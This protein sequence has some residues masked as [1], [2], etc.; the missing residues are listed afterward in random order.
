MCERCLSIIE[1]APRIYRRPLTAI[2]LEWGD[3][4]NVRDA[5][6]S[7]EEAV[8]R[9]G[10]PVIAKIVEQLVSEYE[11]VVKR[12]DIAG[13]SKVK[14]SYTSDLAAAFKVA[15][16]AA[17]RK[18]K[19]QIREFIKSKGVELAVK[20]PHPLKDADKRAAYL[21]ARADAVSEQVQTQISASVQRTVLAA[22]ATGEW[23]ET[24]AETIA[25]TAA[26]SLVASA[27]EIGREAFAAGRLYGYEEIKQEV[28][29]VVYS[30]VLDEKCCD[31]CA[32]M[33]G[34]VFEDPDEG[35]DAAPNAD[36]EGGISRCRCY[37][38]LILDR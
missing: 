7:A 35:F 22:A 2:E 10:K 32:S 14:P 6:E 27:Y 3:V 15:Q 12:G 30:A 16:G 24:I 1:N 19:R 11:G 18:G 4:D 21:D 25:D 26:R 33:D 28:S 34:R 5:M 17:V 8:I 20:K 37:P 29:Y 13:V 36:C 31:V 38:I 23:D 9:S